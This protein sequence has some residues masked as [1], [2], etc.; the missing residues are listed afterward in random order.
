MSNNQCQQ[1]INKAN[2]RDL[3]AAN[4]LV[5]LNWIQIIDFLAVWSWNLMNDLEEQ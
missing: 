4:D 2:S 3:L 1:L 5:M